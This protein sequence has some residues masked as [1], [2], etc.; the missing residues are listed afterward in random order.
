[1][2]ATRSLGRTRSDRDWYPRDG[3]ITDPGLHVSDFWDLAEFMTCEP[4]LTCDVFEKHLHE[5]DEHNGAPWARGRIH[6]SLQIR[7]T[8]LG[9]ASHG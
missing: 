8:S 6:A 9:S 2:R 3:R 4:P 5:D 1:M 7:Q